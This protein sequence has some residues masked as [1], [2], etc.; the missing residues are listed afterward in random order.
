MHFILFQTIHQKHQNYCITII[1]YLSNPLTNT[2]SSAWVREPFLLKTTTI[3]LLHLG[4][5]TSTDAAFNNRVNDVAHL[6][7]AGASAGGAWGSM[8]GI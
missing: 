7:C 4:A 6:S 3:D 5:I 2:F 8:P 1:V